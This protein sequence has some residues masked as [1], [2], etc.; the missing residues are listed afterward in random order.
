[1]SSKNF[2]KMVFG[3]MMRYDISHMQKHFKKNKKKIIGTSSLFLFEKKISF[4]LITLSLIW[5][6]FELDRRWDHDSSCIVTHPYWAHSLDVKN[7]KP[8]PIGIEIRCMGP[9]WRKDK[10]I[11]SL[12][13]WTLHFKLILNQ[14]KSDLKPI[15]E[16]NLIKLGSQLSQ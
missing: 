15:L 10:E 14:I 3:M 7:L 4:L 11:E 13:T 16:I 12:L 6:A 1:M 5:I 8:N 2:Q 9:G